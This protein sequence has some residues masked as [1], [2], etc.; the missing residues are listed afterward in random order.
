MGETVGEL[1]VIAS[2]VAGTVSFIGLFRRLP[3]LWLPTWSRALRVWA[4]SIVLLFI[5]AALLQ[6]APDELAAPV[7]DQAAQ[8]PAP[9]PE[10][11][12]EP[13]EDTGTPE[14]QATGQASESAARTDRPGLRRI[15]G[16]NNIGCRSRDYHGRLTRYA[17]QGDREAWVQALADAALSGE[18]TKFQAGEPVFLTDTA[19][20]SG[21][22]KI[23]HEGELTEYWTA[24]ETVRR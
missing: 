24:M 4:A 12:V 21:L 16:D 13:A 17:V 23:R 11:P 7:P 14:E 15:D 9:P 5:G 8:K 18:C 20:F 2:I 3:S 10:A 1:L 22:V 6:D 19:I